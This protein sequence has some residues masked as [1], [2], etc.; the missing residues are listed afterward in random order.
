MQPEKKTSGKVNSQQCPEDAQKHNAQQEREYR[1][2]RDGKMK[3]DK[4][5]SPNEN[6][7][8]KFSDIKSDQK[9]K[10]NEEE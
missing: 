2:Q 4:K 9:K 6:A 1:E 7:S 8:E 10:K 5:D 3:E